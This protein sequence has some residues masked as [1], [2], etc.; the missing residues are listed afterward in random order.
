M[1][2]FGQSYTRWIHR[3]SIPGD[4][5]AAGPQC[6]N[7]DGKK[8]SAHGVESKAKDLRVIG[9]TGLYV[10]DMSVMPLSYAANPVRPL[11]AL[12]LVYRSI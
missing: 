5:H 10:C 8:V 3:A 7:S 11:A 9:T 2:V 4:A 6:S 1:P 12:A